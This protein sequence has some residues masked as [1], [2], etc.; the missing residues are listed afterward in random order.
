[1]GTEIRIRSKTKRELTTR[2]KGKEAVKD[3]S[4]ISGSLGEE[5]PGL[6]LQTHGRESRKRLERG[7]GAGKGIFVVAVLGWK[8]QSRRPTEVLKV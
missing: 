1:M 4:Q 6:V 2:G 5:C 8:N 3:N 7:V